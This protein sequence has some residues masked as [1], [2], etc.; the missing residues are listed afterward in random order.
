MWIREAL[1]DLPAGGR[2]AVALTYVRTGALAG[3]AVLVGRAVDAALGGTL[4]GAPDG[5]GWA[6]PLWLALALVAVAALAGGR[7]EATPEPLQAREEAGWRRRVGGA[8]LSPRPGARERTRPDGEL[9]EAATVAVEKTA[10]YRASFLGPTLAAFTAPLIV[11]A[12]WAL[13]IDLPSALALTAFVA[14]VPATIVAASRNLRRPNA[15]YRRLE[16]QDSARYL[17]MLETLGTLRVFGADRRY[18]D[19]HAASA[20]ATMAELGRLLARNQTMIVVNDAVFGILMTG[21][22]VGLALWRLLDGAITPGLAA[23]A[24]LLTVLLREPIDRIGR[25]FY[26]GLGGR[27]RRDQL[28]KLLADAPAGSGEPGAAASTGAPAVSVRGLTVRYGETTVLHGVDLDLPAGATLAVVGPSGSG[29]TTLLRALQGLLAPDAGTVALDGLPAGPEQLVATSGSVSQHPG[30]L[31]ASIAENLRLAAAYATD[32][33]LWAALERA[34]LADDVR[35]MPDGLATHVGDA[36]AR[37]SGG[38]ARRLAIARAVLRDAPLLLLDEPTADLDRRTEALV[39]GSLAE[40]TADRTVVVVAHRL[41]AVDG[42][43][44]VCVL[45]AGRVAAFGP[46]DELAGTAG[47]LA[48]ARRVEA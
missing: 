25:T 2:T 22:A 10:A 29:K 32:E 35:A 37:L 14:L 11:L 15:A 7:A 28:E 17:A 39:R 24:V 3:A 48:D 36:G 30:L 33:E 20:R 8:L 42:A 40:L 18:R 13:A 16:A 31:G 1:T 47:Y 12:V 19:R 23:A 46:P 41:A 6:A 9:L 5:R 21:A 44:L 34:H 27:A 4:G 43:D 26:V 45:D 38:Q